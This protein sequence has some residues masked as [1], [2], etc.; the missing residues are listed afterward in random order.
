MGYLDA[1]DADERDIV[2]TVADF[3]DQQVKPVVRELEHTNTYPEALIESMKELGIYG[4][5][6]PEE[7]GGVDV[8][9]QCYVLVTE[10]LARGWMSLAGAMGGHT[11]VV[12]L[13]TRFG[14]DAQKA[15]WLPRLAT[16]EVRATMALT[17]P[18]GGSDLQALRTTARE[19]DGEYRVNGSKTWITNARRAGLTALLCKTDPDAQPR[20]RGIS[21][22]LVEPGPGLEVSRDL[23][24]LGYKGVESCELRFDDCRVPVDHL[25]GGVPGRGFAQMMKGLETG[26][27]QVAARALGVGRAAFDDALAYAQERESFGQPIWKHQSI[28]NYLADM[29]TG[30]EA[31]R[32]LTLYAAREYDAG[33]RVDMEAGMAKLFASETAMTVALN[34]VRIHGGYGYSTEFDVERYFRDAPL[35]IVGE[36]TNEIQRNVIVGQLVKRATGLVGG[37]S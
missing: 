21:V 30:L 10:E 4:L 19:V 14:T 15:A 2:R 28:G 7:Y 35:M 29:A 13:L 17:E 16:G 24:K 31:A 18:G 25:L 32:Q 27:L 37:S 23:P 26:R 8:S 5:A 36:G 6:V 34:A 22:L 3:V 11:V 20:S 12:T 1:L 33:R 9:M